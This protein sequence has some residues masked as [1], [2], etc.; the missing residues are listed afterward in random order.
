MCFSLRKENIE[1]SNFV[2]LI[3]ISPKNIQT[4]VKITTFLSTG[5]IYL[6]AAIFQQ[7]S[8]IF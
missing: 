7:K 3:E 4:G 6:M 8:V 2:S 1:H 5:P